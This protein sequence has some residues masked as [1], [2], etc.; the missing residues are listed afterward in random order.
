MND[1]IAS[2]DF[3]DVFADDDLPSDPYSE[4]RCGFFTG[5]AN[6]YTPRSQ[7]WDDWN[8][9]YADGRHSKQETQ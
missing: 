4:G 3:E 8:C 5:A 6:P 2:E 7:D 1:Q 9:G